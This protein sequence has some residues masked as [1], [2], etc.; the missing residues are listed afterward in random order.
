MVKLMKLCELNMVL[1]SEGDPRFMTFLNAFHSSVL[2]CKIVKPC[3]YQLTKHSRLL[4]TEIY[5][6]FKGL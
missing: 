5:M 4:V 2:R 6:I 3:D 1:Q